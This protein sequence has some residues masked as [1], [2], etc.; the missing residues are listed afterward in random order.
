MLHAYCLSFFNLDQS[1]GILSSRM[2]FWSN[3]IKLIQDPES[4][5]NSILHSEP[6]EQQ[7]EVSGLWAHLLA[8]EGLKKRLICKTNIKDMAFS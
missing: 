7:D 4:T 3:G 6:M 2:K 1:D 8:T 5:H